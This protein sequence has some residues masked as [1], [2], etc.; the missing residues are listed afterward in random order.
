MTLGMSV[1]LFNVRQRLSADCTS[2]NLLVRHAAR[3]PRPLALF[4]RDRTVENVDSIG[5]VVRR[6]GQ[7]YAGKP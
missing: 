4:F 1:E 2:L 6:C 5:L 7:C 3:D